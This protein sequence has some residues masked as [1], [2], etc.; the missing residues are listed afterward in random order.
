M[1]REVA[2]QAKCVKCRAEG[3]CDEFRFAVVSL[4]GETARN[5][6]GQA[7]GTVW[8]WKPIG[9]QGGWLCEKCQSE[10]YRKSFIVE[11]FR[12]R[13]IL[14]SVAL[15]ACGAS[16]FLVP[17]NHF[18][19]DNPWLTVPLLLAV[20]FIASVFYLFHKGFISKERACN[21]FAQRALLDNVRRQH[22]EAEVKVGGDRAS[23][24]GEIELLTEMDWE[25][26][27]RSS[28]RAKKRDDEMHKDP[29]YLRALGQVMGSEGDDISGAFGLFKEWRRSAHARS[30]GQQK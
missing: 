11:R 5:E 18:T 17:N 24:S 29:T 15:L 3:Q 4:S 23:H 9:S 30:N 20:A 1:G 19:N 2:M 7:T 8:T 16:F 26:M 6:Y 12:P 22:G 14:A 25:L 13:A 27:E 10:E 28:E 21:Y